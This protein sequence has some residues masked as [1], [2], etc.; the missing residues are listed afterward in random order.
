MLKVIFIVYFKILG[1]TYKFNC[2][3]TRSWKDS[4]L[5]NYENPESSQTIESYVQDAGY[6]GMYGS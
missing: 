3:F 2:N 4:S 1:V 6:E 5:Q